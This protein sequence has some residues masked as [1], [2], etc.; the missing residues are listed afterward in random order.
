LFLA[1]CV[2][3]LFVVNVPLEFG[4]LRC[5]EV[6]GVDHGSQGAPAPFSLSEMGLVNTN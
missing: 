2:L 5:S 1:C 6:L 4:H 3:N